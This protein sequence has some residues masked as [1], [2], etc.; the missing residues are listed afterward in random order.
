VRGICAARDVTTEMVAER[1]LRAAQRLTESVI[2]GAGALVYAKDLQGRYILSN[3]AWRKLHR[4]PEQAQGV[5]DEQLFGPEAAAR[6]R[7]NDLQVV[8]SGEPVLVQE[9]MVLHGQP[10][11]FRSSKFPLYDD[12]GQVYAVCGVST[13]ITDVVEADRRKDEFLAT[14]AHELRNPLAPIRTGSRSCAGAGRSRGRTSARASHGAADH[15]PVRLVDDLL[16][17]SRISRGKLEL[18]LQVLTLEQV[19]RRCAGGQPAGHRRG[20]P[21]AVGRTAGAAAARAR[22]PHAAGAGVQQ[23]GEQREQV[24]ARRRPHR[25]R[26]A[27]KAARRWWWKVSDNGSGITA[28]MLPHVFDLFAQGRGSTHREPRTAG[29]A[30]A[31]GW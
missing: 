8:Q 14:L 31:C 22:R 26:A 29:W 23:P 2:E 20:R 4:S 30:S 27:P 11:T 21:H 28:D 3:Q 9:R 17:V 10:V 12:N 13:D 7:A 19:H 1:K 18:R 15:A 24:H 6:L 25:V 16:D 5:T